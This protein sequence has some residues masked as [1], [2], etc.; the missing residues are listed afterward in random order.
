MS[1]LTMVLE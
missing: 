1:E